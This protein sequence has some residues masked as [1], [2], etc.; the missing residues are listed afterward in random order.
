[1]K[2]TWL[3]PSVCKCFSNVVSYNLVGEFNIRGV[4]GSID[5]SFQ[6]IFQLSQYIPYA[7]PIVQPI[8]IY[9]H[10]KIIFDVR[11]VGGLIP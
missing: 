7:T 9:I 4:R 2:S 6:F 5:S 11:G 8:Y 1:M 10:P 3:C